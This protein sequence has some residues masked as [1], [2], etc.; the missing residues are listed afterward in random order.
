MGPW[1]FIAIAED[2][3]GNAVRKEE[4]VVAAVARNYTEILE[5]HLE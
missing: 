2:A 4:D 1:E 3:E 5:T